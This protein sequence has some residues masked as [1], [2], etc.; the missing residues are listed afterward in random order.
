MY[1]DTV[2]NVSEPKASAFSIGLLRVGV[3]LIG[4]VDVS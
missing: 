1:F 2:G 3:I 4:Q